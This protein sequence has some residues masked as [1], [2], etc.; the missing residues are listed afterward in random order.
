MSKSITQSSDIAKYI[1]VVLYLLTGSLPNFGAIDILA[2]QWVYF[3]SINILSCLYI[4]F[5]SSTINKISLAKLFSSLYIYLYIFYLLWN[6]LS[7]FYAVNPVETLINLP[8]LGNTFFAIFFCY[9]LISSISNRV[10]FI[11]TIF[12]LFLLA[13]MISY[14]YDLSEV[15][16]KEG[17]RVIAIKGFAGNK[18]ITAASIAFKI[19]FAIF[20]YFVL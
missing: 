4:L 7:Y 17:L 9:L 14:Y 18:N 13:E 12:F 6:G 20:L 5:F 2:P 3:G 11:A 15:Y 1:L 10:Y 19:P 8:R 16:P